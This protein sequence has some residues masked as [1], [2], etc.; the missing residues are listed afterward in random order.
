[1]APCPSSPSHSHIHTS[2][3]GFFQFLS[4]SIRLV[5]PSPLVHK[6]GQR[7]SLRMFL[8]NTFLSTSGPLSKIYPILS[9]SFG[10]LVPLPFHRAPLSLHR[11]PAFCPLGLELSCGLES[12][13]VLS[14][15]FS[16]LLRSFARLPQSVP[17]LLL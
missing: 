4:S 13:I 10:S 17:L 3:D 11:D 6:F 7:I 5:F 16:L 1:L 14:S 12:L 8:D 2:L 9:A 15:V